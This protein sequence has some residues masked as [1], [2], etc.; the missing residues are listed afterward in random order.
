MCDVLF[1]YCGVLV[2]CRLFW[3]T[4]RRD[5]SGSSRSSSSSSRRIASPAHPHRCLPPPPP[6][7]PRQQLTCARLIILGKACVHDPPLLILKLLRARHLARGSSRSRLL[8]IRVAA[9]S[10]RWLR[11]PGRA[12]RLLL[13][14]GI[15]G[16]D[17][18]G[19]I[20]GEGRGCTGNTAM[21]VPSLSRGW[22]G[23]TVL[24]APSSPSDIPNSPSHVSV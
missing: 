20:E 23:F 2:S 6:S 22:V 21:V 5:S 9:S 16:G 13:V 17:G 14:A 19:E 10:R 15:H 11:E 4:D 3:A 12:R 24:V 8:G 7:T 1:E 18:E